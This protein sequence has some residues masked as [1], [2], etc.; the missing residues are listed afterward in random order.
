MSRIPPGRVRVALEARAGHGR[1]NVGHVARRDRAPLREVA[2]DLRGQVPALRRVVR[3]FVGH[4]RSPRGASATSSRRASDAR[5]GCAVVR[6]HGSAAT[7]RPGSTR[8]SGARPLRA[9]ARRPRTARSP[10]VARPAASPAPRRRG[11]LPGCPREPVIEGR[12]LVPGGE[13]LVP[14]Q[15]APPER[16]L[17][18]TAMTV[19]EDGVKPRPEVRLVAQGP[20]AGRTRGGSSPGRDRP[21]PRSSARDGARSPAPARGTAGAGRSVVAISLRWYRSW[22]RFALPYAETPGTRKVAGIFAC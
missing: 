16:P 3:S 7:S 15:E 1:T 22:I 18:P 2:F 14:R 9:R 6:D 12:G 20:A 17:A 10:P 5:S 4:G 8:R 11:A 19:E 13:R 21:R